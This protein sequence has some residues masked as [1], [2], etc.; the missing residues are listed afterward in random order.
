MNTQDSPLRFHC[1][2]SLYADTFKLHIAAGSPVL[3]IA[4]PIEFEPHQE[5][6]VAPDRPA[7]SLRQ[8]EAQTLIDSLW[9]A[10]LRPTQGKQSEGVTAAQDRHLQDMRALA[11]AKL[12]VERP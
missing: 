2:Y 5:G 6:T 12:G 11:F 4:K 10:G 3:A 8:G 7:L 1:E 9:S